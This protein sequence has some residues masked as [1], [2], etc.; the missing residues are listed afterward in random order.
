M[1]LVVLIK[2]SHFF[3]CFVP[4]GELFVFGDCGSISAFFGFLEDLVQLLGVK[5][6]LAG[7]V[8]LKEG[9]VDDWL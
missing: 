7:G 3:V 8:F 1:V 5:E 9:M 6:I 2:S 4:V